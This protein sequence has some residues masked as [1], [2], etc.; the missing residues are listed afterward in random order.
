MS[1]VKAAVIKDFNTVETIN[2][3]DRDFI[4]QEY[5]CKVESGAAKIIDEML[6]T[7][8]LPCGKE[9]DD[10]AFFIA[11]MFLRGPWFREMPHE[12]PADTCTQDESILTMMKLIPEYAGHFCKMT[13]NLLF[14]P[15][16]NQ[17]RFITSDTPVI[18]HYQKANPPKL[19]IPSPDTHIYFPISSQ[20]CLV[21]DYDTNRKISEASRKKTA[22][23]NRLLAD[24]CTRIIVSRNR[25]FAWMRNNRTVCYTSDELVKFLGEKKKAHG[26]QRYGTL[27][28]DGEGTGTDPS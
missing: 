25:D 3:R 24:K 4:E 23:I 8:R 27:F 22:L 7:N 14:I 15:F 9:W 13:P 5:L 26:N 18:P 10:L 12:Q 19:W 21:L 2:K 17:A 1:I 28:R 16:V 11:V 6:E 20:N